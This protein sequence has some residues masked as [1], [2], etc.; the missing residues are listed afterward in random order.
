MTSALEKYSQLPFT[1]TEV[2]TEAITRNTEEPLQKKHRPRKMLE[3]AVK[4]GNLGHLYHLIEKHIILDQKQFYKCSDWDSYTPLGMCCHHA[5]TL[6]HLKCFRL[7]LLHGADVNDTARKDCN[8]EYQ[9]LI[10][11]LLETMENRGDD[12]VCLHM[13]A[14]IVKALGPEDLGQWVYKDDDTGYSILETAARL[15]SEAGLLAVEI[16]LEVTVHFLWLVCILLD[17][18]ETNFG[19]AGGVQ[20]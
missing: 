15:N 7:L 4:E 17:A 13:L 20:G 16:L 19:S 1:D 6:D 18:K 2:E 3:N 14:T 8:D 12:E 10:V 5:D 11:V 9:Q